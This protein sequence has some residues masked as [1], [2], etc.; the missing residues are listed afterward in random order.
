MTVASH[1]FDEFDAVTAAGGSVR[2]PAGVRPAEWRS[3]V[4]RVRF[5]GRD[6]DLTLA[7]FDRLL[8]AGR[9][10]ALDPV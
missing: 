8:Q 7:E 5:G 9:V 3:L 2:S 4:F 10:R 6:V 1:Y